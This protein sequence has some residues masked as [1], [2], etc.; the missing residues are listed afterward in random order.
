MAGKSQQKRQRL[1]PREY[2]MHRGCVTS[3]VQ[4][5][6]HAGRLTKS[7]H[8]DARGWYQID[9]ELADQEW[10][11]T[12]RANMIPLSGPTAPGCG[13]APSL[14]EA[15]ARLDL[16]K[17]ELAEIELAEKRGELVQA[18][19]VEARLSTV[20][21]RCKTKLLGIPSRARQQDPGLTAAQVAL[22][23]S[24]V[25]EALEDLAAEAGEDEEVAP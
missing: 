15:R 2:A 23:K 14:G 20:F 5:A 16:A 21:G 19:E 1:S 10:A 18:G 22:I 24:L 6:I 12:T 7:L 4:Q 9:V 13:D 8:R 3:A 17:A 11:A 25:R